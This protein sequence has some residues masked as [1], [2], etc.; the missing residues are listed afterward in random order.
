MFHTTKFISYPKGSC[1]ANTV[2]SEN[3][4]KLLVGD[5]EINCKLLI[6]DKDGTIV[7]QRPLLLYLAKARFTSLTQLLDEHV[8]EEWAKAIGANLQTGEIHDEGP[9]AKAPTREEVLVAALIIYQ[10][11]RVGWDTA[12]ELAEKAYEEADKA[13][14]PPYGAVLLSG[15]MKT[16]QKLKAQGFKT[17]LATTD[18]HRRA[19]ESLKKLKIDV[20]FDV[21]VGADDVE[22]GKPAPDMILKACKLTKCSPNDAVIVGDSYSDMLMGKNAR[23]KLC[24]GVLTGPTSKE[25]LE[26]IADIVVPSITS[27]LTT[28]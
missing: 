2:G 9:F 4:P 18:S 8:A 11:R 12:K 17:A 19:Q 25:K 20:Y 23:V 28:K 13:M 3:M 27:L 6:F 10:C 7:D 16:L 21:V 15:A 26:K 5:R 24:I 14:T 22:K 1:L